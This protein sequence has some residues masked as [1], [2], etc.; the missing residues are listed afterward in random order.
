MRVFIYWNFNKKLWSIRSM[1]TGRVIDRRTHACITDCTFKVSAAGRQRVL[2]DRR[3]NVHAGVVG[4]LTTVDAEMPT[5]PVSYNPY[6]YETFINK[7]NLEPVK[8]SR[9]VCFGPNGLC[10]AQV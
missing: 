2:R 9:L 1:E 10:M 8:E 6:K 3:K 7:I 4:M 5:T